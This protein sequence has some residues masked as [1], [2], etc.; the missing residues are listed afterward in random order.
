MT[1]AQQSAVIT[2]QKRFFDAEAAASAAQSA[3]VQAEAAVEAAK[4][5]ATV[6]APAQAQ[7]LVK[8]ANDAYFK[9]QADQQNV[10]QQAQQ[11][12]VEL[13]QA[14]IDL[15]QAILGSLQT[16]AVEKVTGPTTTY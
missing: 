14:Q 3:S 15:N 9:A 2:A 13:S 4:T 7:A 12:Q 1:Q 10:I 16:G 5:N 8:A 11:A 6:T